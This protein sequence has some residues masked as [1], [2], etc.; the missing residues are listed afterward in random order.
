MLGGINIQRFDRTCIAISLNL[1][2]RQ[3]KQSARS[4]TGMTSM[5]W[6]RHHAYSRTVFLKDSSGDDLCH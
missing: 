2:D 1:T 3:V 6:Q 4:S 5:R